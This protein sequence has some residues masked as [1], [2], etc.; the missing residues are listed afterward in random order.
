MA[1]GRSAYEPPGPVARRLASLL[2]QSVGI[3][4]PI[5]EPGSEGG[6][7]DPKTVLSAFPIAFSVWLLIENVDVYVLTMPALPNP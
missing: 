4:P 2:R 7:D 6:E 1:H 5:S 3:G